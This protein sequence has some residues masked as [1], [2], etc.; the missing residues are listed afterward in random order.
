[1]QRAWD[2]RKTGQLGSAMQGGWGPNYEGKAWRDG[3]GEVCRVRLQ[4]L[5]L[6]PS[7]LGGPGRAL[8]KAGAVPV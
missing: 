3:P 8:S 7:P 6:V 4:C 5:G 2:E 1:M